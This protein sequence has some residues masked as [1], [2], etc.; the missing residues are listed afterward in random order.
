[1]S[2][3]EIGA[4]PPL[5]P[6]LRDDLEGTIIK[7][8]RSLCG[9]KEITTRA[10]GDDLGRGKLKY[11]GEKYACRIVTSLKARQNKTR[12]AVLWIL[13]QPLGSQKRNKRQ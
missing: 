9:G 2:V 11:R 6:Q 3:D 10:N 8:P 5:R 12:R 7:C 1:M 4:L 13:K